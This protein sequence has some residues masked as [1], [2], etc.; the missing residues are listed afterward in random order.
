[1]ENENS[2]PRILG[3]VK[4]GSAS[5][6]IYHQGDGANSIPLAQFAHPVN[7]ACSIEQVLSLRELCDR[8]LDA[9]RPLQVHPLTPVKRELAPQPEK[10]VPAKKPA[11]KRSKR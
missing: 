8:I 7:G 6:T 4:A 1:M 11:S 10:A 3:V 9:T 2:A 5:A